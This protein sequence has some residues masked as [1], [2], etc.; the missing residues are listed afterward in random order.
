M[1]SPVVWGILA[2]LA[3][4]VSALPINAASARSS[5]KD[6]EAWADE[7][8]D[9]LPSEIRSRVK[10]FGRACGVRPAAAHG[11]ALRVSN[12]RFL[13]LHYEALS[14]P[15]QELVCKES[16]CLHEVYAQSARGYTRLFSG[17][18]SDEGL[19]PGRSGLGLNLFE[20]L[21]WDGRRFLP[22]Q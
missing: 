21:R 11:F 20:A 16:T 8:I 3:L 17:F 22:E 10:A 1:R 7:H 5:F 19:F 12:G 15:K 4:V 13:V 18:V 14:C 2:A 6:H 9:A